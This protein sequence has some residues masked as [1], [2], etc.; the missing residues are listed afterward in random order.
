[1][2][3]D[4]DPVR[5]L[6]DPET[7]DVL[8]EALSSATLDEPTAQQLV[9]SAAKAT[10]TT[11]VTLKVV[12]TILTI[13]LGGAVGVVLAIRPATAPNVMPPTLTAASS[14]VS[15]VEPSSSPPPLVVPPSVEASAAIVPSTTVS[16]PAPRRSELA[17][18]GDAQRALRDGDAAAAL[19]AA[20]E[21]KR[22]YAGGSFT[23]E[24]EV[25]AIDALLRLGRRQ[26]AEMRAASFRTAWP[27]S[28]HLRRIEKLLAR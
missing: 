10:A 3:M 16:T 9:A 22:L 12:L 21:H 20:A 8:R 17:I 7:S 26:E 18:L 5:L 6:D 14:P 19:A 1:M 27:D 13:L 2:T 23:Q 11:T 25:I 24:R 28:T 15:S 4:R